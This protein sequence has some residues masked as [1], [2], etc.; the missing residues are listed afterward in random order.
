MKVL[1]TGLGLLGSAIQKISPDFVY[2]KRYWDLT[3]RR[4]ADL[5]L[6]V[7]KPDVV[8]HTAARVG[9]VKLNA[10][11]Q[12]EMFYENAVM[13]ANVI[14]AAV[15]C[16]VKKV[17]AFGSTCAFGD[18]DRL[19]ES[20][21]QFGE[22]YDGNFGY[23]YAKRMTEI[24]LRAAKRQTGMG[25]SYFIPV[26]LYGPRDN[27][28]LENAHVIPSLIHKCYLAKA[29]G[30]PLR[31]WGDGSAIRE[32]LFAGDLA[33]IVVDTLDTDCDT[34][35]VSAGEAV[36]VREMVEVVSRAMDFTGEVVWGGGPAGKTERPHADVTKMKTLGNW[37]FTSF[38]DGVKETVDWF[39]STYPNLR[40]ANELC[41]LRESNPETAVE[42]VAGN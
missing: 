29:S 18:A 2:H 15:E 30:D 35:I 23:G 21:V 39:V 10:A 34:V 14:H 1:V 6:T 41:D 11:R 7:F 25:Y 26:S 4:K 40:G 17:V 38:A 37:S 42:T 27:F 22:P 13:S 24:H 9:G 32:V 33:R 20:D 5:M 16:D 31:M 28:D 19:V 8:I 3:H 36:S 12:E